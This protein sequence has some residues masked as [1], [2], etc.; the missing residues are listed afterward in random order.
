MQ[1]AADA[2]RKKKHAHVH[3]VDGRKERDEEGIE[4]LGQYN[5]QPASWETS[6]LIHRVELREYRPPSLL[7]C[8]SVGGTQFLSGSSSEP[9]TTGAVSTGSLSFSFGEATRTPARLCGGG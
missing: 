8:L 4:Q 2:L 1:R 9:L 7:I 6:P 5:D 3:V